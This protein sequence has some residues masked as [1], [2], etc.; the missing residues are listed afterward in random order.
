MRSKKK[1]RKGYGYHCLTAFNKEF[2][3]NNCTCLFV[4]HVGVVFL[5]VIKKN[6]KIQLIINRTYYCAVSNYSHKR[7]VIED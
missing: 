2:L 6:K 4:M 5:N 7:S 3:Y 1:K